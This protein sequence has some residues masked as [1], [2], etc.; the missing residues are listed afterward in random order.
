[1][2]RLLLNFGVVLY[3]SGVVVRLYLL[4]RCV[5]KVCAPKKCAVLVKI[6]LYLSSFALF[7]FLI[8][9]Y[10]ATFYENFSYSLTLCNVKDAYPELSTL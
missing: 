6:I 5:L 1:M 8:N 4:V 7:L 10:I 9:R 2:W 3:V